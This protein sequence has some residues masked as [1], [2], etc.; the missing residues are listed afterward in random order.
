MHIIETKGLS[1]HFTKGRPILDQINLRVK[2]GSIYGFLGPNGAGKTTT[3]RLILGLL[4]KQQGEVLI[5]G[6]NFGKHRTQVLRRIG[7]LIESPSIY[8]QLTAAE[9]LAVWQKIYRCPKSRIPE[10]LH[11]VGLQDTGTK[12]AHQFSLGMKQ[13]LSIA[14]ALLHEPAL[15]V[16]D[17][18]TNGLDPGGIVEIREMLK[19][20]N[21]E[22]GV[23]VL[24]SSHLLPEIEKLATDVGIIHRGQ[25]LFEGTLEAL[26]ERQRQV[27][28]IAFETD[29]SPRT[30]Q[31]LSDI[32][33]A[34]RHDGSSIT[35]P[36][37]D[38]Q[39]IAVLNRKL[40]EH[41]I[42]VHRIAT[43]EDDLETIFMNLTGEGGL[44]D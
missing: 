37:V 5:F 36:S 21:R 43:V 18:P 22:M 32:G 16:L 25:L 7:S 30:L 20:L 3:L 6:K 35:I 4:R 19:R 42:G 15:L 27:S 41:G 8:G 26:L 12:R 40:V 1:H 14:V 24:I 39:A 31:L 11:L 10:A 13:R 34:A 23:T 38:K 44:K 28:R 2:E 17:E 29:D 9:N 33:Q